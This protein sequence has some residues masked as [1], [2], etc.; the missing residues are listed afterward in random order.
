MALSSSLMRSVSSSH[1]SVRSSSLRQPPLVDQTVSSISLP[2]RGHRA[3]VALAMD[4][5]RIDTAVPTT[6]DS[7]ETNTTVGSAETAEATKGD[8]ETLSNYVF[9]EHDYYKVDSTAYE[10]R[11]RFGARWVLGTIFCVAIPLYKRMRRIEDKVEKTAE[12]AIEVI[13]KV[14]E[15]TEKVASDVAN[16]LPGD[17]NIKEAALKIEKI[18]EEVDKDAGK[19]EAILHKVDEIRE[20]VDAI[21]NPI[22]KEGE[23]VKKEKQEEDKS[24]HITEKENQEKEEAKPS[25][26]QS[27]TNGESNDQK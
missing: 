4:S 5:S 8:P 18:A 24:K 1:R 21:V 22:I 13:E 10:R 20:E 12:T 11:D 25:T 2:V 7:K 27:Q 6:E 19:A 15:V 3:V 23:S 16:A 17:G 9:R 26:D 14:S